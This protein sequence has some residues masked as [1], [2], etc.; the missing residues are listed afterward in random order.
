MVTMSEKDQIDQKLENLINKNRGEK[1]ERRGEND[2]SGP[3][4]LWDSTVE[5]VQKSSVSGS[6]LDDQIWE[7][8]S[9]CQKNQKD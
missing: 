8:L 6:T 2:D 3:N 5:A 9:F 1:L 4:R 7:L